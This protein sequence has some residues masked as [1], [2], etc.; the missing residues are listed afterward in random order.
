MSKT[1]CL[2]LVGG[3][4]VGAAV[5]YY[6]SLAEAHQKHDRMMDIVIT[7]AD[8]SRVY[9]YVQAADREGLADYLIGFISRM[10]AAG[11]EIA[12]IPAVTPHFCIREL[13]S[14]SPIPVINLFESLN[15]ELSKRSVRRV[16]VFGTRFVVESALFGFLDQVQIVSPRPEEV[17]EIH[18]I[19]TKLAQEG[20]G[21]EEQ[22][23]RLTGLAHTLC[24][25][26]E[27]DAILLAGTD[28]ALVFNQSN[29][30]FPHV[31][32]AEV[33]IQ[34]IFKQLFFALGNLFSP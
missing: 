13:V 20:K 33:H 14:R 11:A 31:D 17:N 21:S 22:H 32:C 6:Q 3:L 23:R 26:D 2:G 28:L 1:R 29:T 12:V 25:R 5:H 24:T 30:D 27:V 15:E 16:A 9:E 18:Q 10:H 19:Y 8:V 7:H 34:A 4:G